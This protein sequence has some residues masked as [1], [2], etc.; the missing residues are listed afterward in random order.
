MYVPQTAKTTEPPPI[1]MPAP[2][3]THC[4]SHHGSLTPTV[5]IRML[6][7]P[8]SPSRGS[9]SLSGPHQPGAAA[10]NEDLSS[11]YFSGWMGETEEPDRWIPSLTRKQRLLAFFAFSCLSI[12]CF[13]MAML[14]LPFIVLKVRRL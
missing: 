2:H 9:L 4:A 12:F 5:G 6:R 8:P 1:P 11:S 13:T 7:I 3:R 14:L 10:D